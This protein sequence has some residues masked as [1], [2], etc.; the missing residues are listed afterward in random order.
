MDIQKIINDVIAKLKADDNL[1]EKFK[2]D[3]R[4]RDALFDGAVTG[5]YCA[6]F[7]YDPDALPYGGAFGSHRGEIQ[8]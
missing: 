2:F 8:M 5:D 3:Y 1:L 6:H 7:W 4:L